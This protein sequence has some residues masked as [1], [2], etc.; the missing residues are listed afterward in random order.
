MRALSVVLLMLLPLTP[1]VGGCDLLLGGGGEG[2]GEG[3]VLCR[4]GERICSDNGQ[5]ILECLA[6][7]GEPVLDV[8]ESSPP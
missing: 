3:E 6:F 7:G 2:E 5:A 8:L 1:M 4:P